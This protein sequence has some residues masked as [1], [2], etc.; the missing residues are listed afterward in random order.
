MGPSAS[1]DRCRPPYPLLSPQPGTSRPC[2][3]AVGAVRCRSVRRILSFAGK[4][5]Y[6]GSQRRPSCRPIGQH[7]GPCETDSLSTWTCLTTRRQ[8]CSASSPS[9]RMTAVDGHRGLR[10]LTCGTPLNP[11]KRTLR[12]AFRKSYNRAVRALVPP[13]DRTLRAAAWF[14]NLNRSERRRPMIRSDPGCCDLARPLFLARRPS[15]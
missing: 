4:P 11:T 8:G 3:A 6:L 2:A 12:S 13:T 10:Y 7:G 15:R 1:V 5:S 14:D 9:K